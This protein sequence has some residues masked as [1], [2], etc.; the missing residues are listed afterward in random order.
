MHSEAES[1]ETE[2]ESDD[3]N[4]IDGCK[5]QLLK[6]FVAVGKSMGVPYTSKKVPWMTIRKHLIACSHTF[7][8]WPAA[9]PFPHE[10]IKSDKAKKTN[11]TDGSQGIKDLG[12]KHSQIPLMALRNHEVKLV[13]CDVELVLNNIMLLITTATP[14]S[15]D[16]NLHA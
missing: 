3:S 8:G 5:K 15:D 13:P 7:E 2:S 14:T 16:P 11:G 1:N 9:C 4:S 6:L 10:T 12:T